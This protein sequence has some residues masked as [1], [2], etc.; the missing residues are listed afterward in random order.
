M[1]EKVFVV[2]GDCGEY[3]DWRMWLVRAF[4]D[5]DDAERETARLTAW[6]KEHT[7]QTGQWDIRWKVRQKH[8]VPGDE[9]GEYTDWE[10]P[11]Y[12]VHEVPVGVVE[13]WTA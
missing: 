1:D 4:N 5:K 13:K 9:D 6:V 10:P 12:G 11:R 7:E 3:S 2:V 8:S